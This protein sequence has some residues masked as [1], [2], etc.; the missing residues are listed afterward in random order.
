M[1]AE[2][3][4]WA[5]R[6]R[7]RWD[8]AASQNFAMLVRSRSR[9]CSSV[10]EGQ[11]LVSLMVRGVGGAGGQVSQVGQSHVTS[12]SRVATWEVQFE[13]VRSGM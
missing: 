13:M 4:I 3:F 6:R 1:Y 10:W 7:G 8:C 2:N 5:G 11:L 12:G 9:R